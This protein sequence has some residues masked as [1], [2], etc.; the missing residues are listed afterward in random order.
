M[1]YGFSAEIVIQSERGSGRIELLRDENK[2]RKLIKLIDRPN[3]AA[4]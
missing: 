2:G 4:D 3:I 1:P